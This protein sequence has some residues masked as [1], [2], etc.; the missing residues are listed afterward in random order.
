[1]NTGLVTEHLSILTASA[2]ERGR[3]VDRA[4]GAL[5]DGG[6]VILPTE[7]V[8]G[9]AALASHPGAT[10][11]LRRLTRRGP[12]EGWAWHAP[13]V[14]HVE[15]HRPLTHAAH[16]RL[17]RR[18]A[19][20]PVT[21]LFDAAPD[22]VRNLER[23]LG[24]L[25]GSLRVGDGFA[26]RIPSA[27]FAADVLGASPFPVVA[28]ALVAGGGPATR[29]PREHDPSLDGVSL[30]IDAGPTR[31]GKVS[32]PVRLLATGGYAVGEGGPMDARHIDKVMERTILFVCT[33]NTCR[34]PMAEAIARHLIDR[35]RGSPIRTKVRS[36]GVAA[37]PGAE[38][39]PEAVQSLARL[40]VEL[41]GHASRELTRGMVAE[42][43]VIFTMT[44]SHARE[45]VAI[46]P[47]ARAKVRTLDDDGAG[48]PDPIG[49]SQSIYDQ[50]ARRL[51]T[52]VERRLEELDR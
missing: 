27:E 1:M 41:V 28:D 46:D 39:T 23:S 29:P 47:T 15:E 50:T 16:R 51:W 14:A 42:A 25:E 34:S 4:V 5:R 37:A 13:S 11:T 17:L 31:H 35:S 52:L 36:A 33:G 45:V 48:V 8:Y 49:G 38:A 9:L 22:E 26:V 3:A 21:F 12:T 10:Q 2:A 30:V 6:V 40:G 24:A 44:E 19:P 32:T 7:T 20:G 43:E 18:L